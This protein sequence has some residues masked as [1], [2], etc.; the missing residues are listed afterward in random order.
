MSENTDSPYYGI[1]Y[2]GTNANGGDSLTENLNLYYNV[3][4]NPRST[5]AEDDID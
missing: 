5:A 1:A 2:N 4:S 3:R